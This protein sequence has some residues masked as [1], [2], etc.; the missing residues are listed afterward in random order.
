M[1]FIREI[2][3]LEVGFYDYFEILRSMGSVRV[4]ISCNFYI[5]G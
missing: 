3:F 2:R 5:V 4:S 1:E